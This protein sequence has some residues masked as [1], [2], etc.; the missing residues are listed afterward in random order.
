MPFVHQHQ[1]TDEESGRAVSYEIFGQQL[2]GKQP[3]EDVE[4]A[5]AF[6]WLRRE[7]PIYWAVAVHIRNED[8]AAT[9]Q[10]MRR[11]KA[12]GGFVKG[13]ADVAIQGAPSMACEIKSLSKSAKLSPEQIDYLNNVSRV[14]GYACVAYGAAGFVLAFTE[15]LAMQPSPRHS[16]V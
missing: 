8:R 9:A 10:A 1:N 7:H 4:M 13:A 16:D 11:I 14:G 15:W 6:N 2:S 3:S 5:S 12:Q